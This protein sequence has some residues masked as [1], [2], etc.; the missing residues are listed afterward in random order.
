MDKTIAI[1]KPVSVSSKIRDYAQLTKMRLALLVVFSAA[2]AFLIGTP[3]ELDWGKFAL[4]LLGGFLVTG[5]AN[6]INQIMEKDLD[7]LMD[8]TLSRPLPDSRMKAVEAIVVAIVFGI[9]GLL[10][11]TIFMNIAS[12]I[13]G[14]IALVSY[15]ILYTPLKKITPFAVFV[16]AFPGAIPPLLGWVAATNQFSIEAWVLFSIQ[17][18]W[19]FPHFWAIAWVMNDDYKKAG[20][21]LLPSKGGRDKSSAFQAFV[22]AFSLIPIGF[23]P[24]FFSLAGVT[25]MVIITCAGLMFTWQ[26]WKLYSECS[27]KAA[28]QLMFGSFIYLPV[29]QIAIVLNKI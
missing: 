20:F 1:N 22:Y 25:S 5:S 6:A 12:G 28:R 24:Y 10:I 19:Q 18:L 13:L 4:L 16:G 9:A 14:L 11:L 15:T 8:R 7:K 17:F 26:A 23:T 29:V 2:M 3:G 27:L 21:E